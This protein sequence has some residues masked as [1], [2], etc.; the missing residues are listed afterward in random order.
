MNFERRAKDEIVLFHDMESREC[1]VMEI[2]NPGRC[3]REK[4]LCLVGV[5]V[6]DLGLK[7]DEVRGT[8]CV[9]DGSQVDLVR[10]CEEISNGS[11]GYYKL[12]IIHLCAPRSS[13]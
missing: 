12:S 11:I 7:F 6:L 1:R 4:Y 2:A 10:A 13:V 9:V 8:R 5:V 3:P